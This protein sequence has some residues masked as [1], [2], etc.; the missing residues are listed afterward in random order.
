MSRHHAFGTARRSATIREAIGYWF[1]D[2]KPQVRRFSPHDLRSTMKSHLRSLGVDR[3]IDL[4]AWR[5]NSV[6]STRH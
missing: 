3:A 4:E 5:T 6:R 2:E 1:D